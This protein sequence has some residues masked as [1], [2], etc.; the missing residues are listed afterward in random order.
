M[1]T[2]TATLQPQVVL[3]LRGALQSELTRACEDKPESR[4]DTRAGWRPVL[5]RLSAA[6]RGLDLIGWDQPMAQGSVTIALDAT[7]IDAL[8]TDADHFRWASE[9]TRTESAGGRARAARQAE[10]IEQFLASIE[11]PTPL[12]IPAAAIPL[13]R[14][15]AQEGIKDVS[16]SMD[17]VDPRECCRRLAAICEL[18]DAIGWS[19]GEEPD[20]EVDATEHA[21]TLTEVAP[22]LLET[23]A[24][25]VSEHQDGDPEKT[26]VEK[27]LGFLT[28]IHA[29]AQALN[30]R[31]NTDPPGSSGR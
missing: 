1:N 31:Q 14:E 24:Q 15:C 3:L 27:E 12:T 23:L 2:I 5:T 8:E 30:R 10:V 29:H 11:R 17:R 6:Y 22:P 18:L 13:V 16:D 9:Q 7:M 21:H 28:E 19:R 4:P 25:N 26:K 20:G